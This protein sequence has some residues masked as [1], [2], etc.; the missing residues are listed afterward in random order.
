V[1]TRIY[2]FLYIAALVAVSLQKSY[3][4]LVFVFV[5]L[6][7]MSGRSA[8]MLA[9]RALLLVAFFSFFI[10]LSYSVMLYMQ[11]QPFWNYFLTLNLRSLDM[12]FLTLLFTARVNIYEALS[13]SKELSFLLVLSVSKIMTMQRVFADYSDAL[14]S[15]RLK[16][17]SRG[18]IYE[19][20]G[21]AIAGFLDR[22]VQ[23]SKEN[24]E[25]MRSRGFHV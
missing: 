18:Q 13:F 12:M 20:L 16:K 8:F 11:N 9:R 24:F 22:S 5:A 4:P 25:A 19:Y 1:R 15:R 2:L 6:F 23:E 17:P 21:S 7:L 14:R 10:T 3:E